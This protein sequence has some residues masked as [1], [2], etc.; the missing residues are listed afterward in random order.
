MEFKIRDLYPD[1]L[2]VLKRLKTQTEKQSNSKYKYYHFILAIALGAIFTYLATW[3]KKDSFWLFLFGTIAV[4]SF[5]F[6]VFMPYE[7]YKAQ[8][9]YKDLLQRLNALIAKGT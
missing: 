8:R 6:A 1:E 4:L 5:A 2:R 3:I 7:L 9:K